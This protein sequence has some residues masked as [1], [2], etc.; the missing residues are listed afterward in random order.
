MTTIQYEEFAAD[1]DRAAPALVRACGLD[2]EE[3]CR[4]F[5]RS[6]RVIATLSA[7]QVRKPVTERTGR[8]RRYE[9]HLRPLVEALKSAGIDLAT[10]AAIS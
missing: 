5:Q 9:R 3:E 10:G 7:M 2:W 8:A 6:D 1:F 4:Y